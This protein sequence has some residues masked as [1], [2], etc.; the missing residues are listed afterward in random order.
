MPGWYHA[1]GDPTATHRYWDGFEWQ[2]GPRRVGS[3]DARRGTTAEVK[4]RLLARLVD[5]LVWLAISVTVHAGLGVPLVRGGTGAKWWIAGL[6][7]LV[8]IGTYEVVLPVLAGGTI[9]KLAM[10]L[11]IVTEGGG[12]LYQHHALLRATPVLLLAVPFFG[13]YLGLVASALSVVAIFFDRRDQALWDKLA[14]TLVV[15]K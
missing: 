4:D 1:S 3:H 7:S 8:V 13:L 15:R 14:R 6:I 9:G 11:G 10:G 2:G 5:L 12:P